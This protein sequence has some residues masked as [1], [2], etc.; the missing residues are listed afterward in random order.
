M[1]TGNQQGAALGDLSLFNQEPEMSQ[2]EY[3]AYTKEALAKLGAAIVQ[4]VTRKD[5]AG[6]I[7]MQTI[8]G[9]MLK[10]ASDRL[11]KDG[12]GNECHSES[13]PSIN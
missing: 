1:K 5:H 6:L 13:V 2:A 12:D 10:S 3:E 9:S 8:I 4:A 11:H 7:T